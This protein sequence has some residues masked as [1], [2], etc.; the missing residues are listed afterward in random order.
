MKF[1]LPIRFFTNFLRISY[2][3][4]FFIQNINFSKNIFFKPLSI[5]GASFLWF[6]LLLQFKKL[7]N[8][9][10]VFNKIPT[11]KTPNLVLPF[12]EFLVEKK[13]HQ[14]FVI[15]TF[16]KISGER[17]VM[18]NLLL[19][20]KFLVKIQKIIKTACSSLVIYNLITVFREK[21]D[22]ILKN[23]NFIQNE[24]KFSP[25]FCFPIHRDIYFSLLKKEKEMNES[26]ELFFS[27]AIE[28]FGF[29]LYLKLFFL[30]TLSRIVKKPKR[31]LKGLL[32]EIILKGSKR[33]SSSSIEKTGKK[34]YKI[35]N[36]HCLSI[37]KKCTNSRFFFIYKKI[38]NN[39]N[40][41]KKKVADFNYIKQEVSN[42]IIFKKKLGSYNNSF[43]FLEFNKKT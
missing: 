24:L 16:S 5:E 17:I 11:K 37:L 15:Q 43:S 9:Q 40:Q 27:S 18:G 14:E 25:I 2:Q 1:C 41:K 29:S 34:V 42:E 33:T 4:I 7:F 28:F 20:F 36:K 12:S 38:K 26:L 31:H 3:K 13:N 21:F 35:L 6:S 23:D 30:K 10:E 19:M 8:L 22:S 32:L 39:M